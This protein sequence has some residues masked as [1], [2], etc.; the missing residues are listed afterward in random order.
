M[1]AGLK[2]KTNAIF[3]AFCRK[4]IT[5]SRNSKGKYCSVRCQQSFQRDVYIESWKRGE[6]S[7][8]S[9]ASQ[10]SSYIYSYLFNVQNEA[11]LICKRKSWMDQ[12]IPLE[13]DHIDGNFFNTTPKNVRLICATCHA[14]TPTYKGR[15]R[16]S[17]KYLRSLAINS[18]GKVIP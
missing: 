14:I 9:G 12:P 4:S 17:G 6:V 2:N 16:G 7:G 3:C 5:P 11:C 18:S 15:N 8:F 13:L 10:V 1:T